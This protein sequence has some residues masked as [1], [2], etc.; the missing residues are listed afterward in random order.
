M[1]HYPHSHT[2]SMW[3]LVS[4]QKDEPLLFRNL[5]AMTSNYF[6]AS[7]K[8]CASQHYP[9]DTSW[10][11]TIDAQCVLKVPV[12]PQFTHVGPCHMVDPLSI[13]L[14]GH[15]SVRSEEE[16]GAS[17]SQSEQDETGVVR[18]QLFKKKKYKHTPSL[19]AHMNEA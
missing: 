13:G 3:K 1:G 17:L 2:F 7:S 11:I 6:R 9:L 8:P 10:G 14:S 19:E 5:G 15:G 16:R 12:V 4:P 18:E